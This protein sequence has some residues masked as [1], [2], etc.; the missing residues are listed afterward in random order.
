VPSTP[1]YA[2]IDA[3]LCAPGQF[4]EIETVELRGRPTRTWKNAPRNV[5]AA[6]AQGASGAGSRELIVLGDER[7]SHEQHYDQ[8]RRFAAALA[9]DYGIE[10][11]DR[12][13][14]AMRNLPEWS[15]AFFATLSIGAIAVPLNAFWNGAELTYAI[16]DCDAKLV[17]ADGERL[18]R[19]A[20]HLDDLKNIAIVGTRLDDRKTDAP[21]PPDVVPF[22]RLLEHE[23]Q[24]AAGHDVEPDDLATIFY[25]SGT[26]S[27]P[28]GVLG[29]HRNMCSN[30]VSL[31]YAG[32]R[33]G[34][35]S[36][37]AGP[38]KSVTGP[39][40]M[41]LPVPLFH[42]TG[43]HSMLFPQTFFGGTLI[44]MRRWD[45]ETALDLIEREHV[46][47]VSGVP[48]MIWDLMHSPTLDA[49]DVSSLA[50]LGG[51]GAA[52]PPELVRRIEEKFPEIPSSTGYGLTE[53]SSA[54]TSISGED[55][56]QHPDSVGVPIPVCE[57]RVLDLDAPDDAGR[58]AD[59]PVGET[60]ELWIHGPNVVPGYW[61]QPEET[62]RAFPGGW[63]RT[64]DIGRF[65][66]DGFLYIVDR[67]K[68]VIIRGGE[69][70]SSLEVEAILFEHPEVL[71]AAVFATP[72]ESLGEEVGAVIRLAADSSATTAALQ[73][74]AASRLAP[75]KVPAHIWLTEEPLPRSAT[76]KVLKREIKESYTQAGMA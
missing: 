61:R 23:P 2:Q 35:R 32:F 28:K 44:F 51:G 56:R 72:H 3:E 40:V 6:L 70:I 5:G 67:A 14:I 42:A 59:L 62:A 37:A 76:G 48:A 34:L 36:T 73:E 8:V 10:K 11:G 17:V 46:T 60:G 21:M 9:E 58:D 22:A 1:T 20:G 12:V 13:A 74:H 38:T 53:T 43:C 18:E 66:Q 19:L 31:M 7:L 4:F 55:Y 52:A 24:D 64:G 50:S 71:E 47:V 29:T 41:L 75:Y 30:L 69:N 26:M 65:D 54:T 27:R 45:A 33:G 49:R 39:P 16:S 25:T 15:V 68:D 63:L 57:V